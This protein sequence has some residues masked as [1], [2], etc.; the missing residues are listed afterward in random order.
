MTFTLF[1]RSGPAPA[2]YW[3]RTFD[4][5]PR[6]AGEARRFV[7]A[8]LPDCIR[9]DEVL[10]AVDELVVN[11]LRHTRSGRDGGSFTVEVARDA[12]RVAVSVLDEGSPSEPAVV[13]TGALDECGRGL[14]LV[15]LTATTWGWHGN[16]AGR[17]VHATFATERS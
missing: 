4:G 17:T 9:M 1:P 13:E 8:L 2:L 12:D 15:S 11:A 7:G 16:E 10:L 14:R 6:E 5:R 3:F